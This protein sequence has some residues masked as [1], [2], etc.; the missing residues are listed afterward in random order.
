MSP[1]QLK[2]A[3][4]VQGNLTRLHGILNGLRAHEVLEDNE[5]QAE[6]LTQCMV[7]IERTQ[8]S[9]HKIEVEYQPVSD[10]LLDLLQN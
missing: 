9:L 10:P 3:A 1:K 5:N 8:H 7:W 4:D 6:M 2:F